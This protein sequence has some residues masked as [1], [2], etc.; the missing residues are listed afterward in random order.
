MSGFRKIDISDFEKIAAAMNPGERPKFA[1]IEIDKLVIDDGYQREMTKHSRKTVERIAS[2]FNWACFEP[3]IVASIGGGR[4]A[5][6]NG[7]HRTTGAALCGLNKGG[8]RKAAYLQNPD[9]IER[10]GVYETRR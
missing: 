8:C 4:F 1:W 7:Q 10:R 2:A 3:P 6:I 5:I 9:R